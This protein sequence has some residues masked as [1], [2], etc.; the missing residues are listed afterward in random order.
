MEVDDLD[1]A[2]ILGRE[3][4]DQP[5]RSRNVR[6]LQIARDDRPVPEQPSEQRLLDLDGPILAR[7][8][9]AARRRSVPCTTN[10]FSVV[11]TTRVRSQRQTARKTTRAAAAS[12]SADAVAGHPTT[13]ANSPGPASANARANEPAS[14]MP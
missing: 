12:R 9:A 2:A 5:L 11:R 3:S 7:R 14:T 8:T 1:H 13:S 6:D 4:I 10:S